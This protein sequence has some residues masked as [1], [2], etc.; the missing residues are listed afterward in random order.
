MKSNQTHISCLL[1]PRTHQNAIRIMFI[2][3]WTLCLVCQVHAAPEATTPRERNQAFQQRVKMHQTGVFHDLAFRCVG[4]V[5]MSG[6]V[7]DIQP[8]PQDPYSFY[9]AYATGG[10]W[11]TENN[12][13]RFTSLFEGQNA[14]A[15]GAIAVDPKNPDT[16]WAG[17]GEANSARSHYSGTGIYKTVDAGK[18]WQ[19]M[20]LR[21]SH[22]IAR[23]LVD[24]DNSDVVI[25]VAMGHL[26]TDNVQ[27]GIFVT[28]DGGQT[29]KKTLYLNPN[30][31]AIDVTLDPADPD[32][33]YAAMWQKTR[34]AWNMDESGAHSGIY[35]STDG[36]ES[37]K[38][39]S[40]FES[41]EHVGRIGLAV[42]P[43]N[44]SVVYALLDN[45]TPKP[46]E[47]NEGDKISARKLPTM[48]KADVLALTDRELGGFLRQSGFHEDHTVESIRAQLDANDLT[49]QD[50]V[51]YVV[52]LNPEAL[53]PQIRG[54]EVYRSEDAGVTWTKMNL[55]DLDSMYN[56]AGY[57]FGQ[58]R[59]A[60]DNEDLIYIM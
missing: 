3:V 56:I 34:T 58:I 16:L 51:D 33:L 32:I 9:V 25:V 21:D 48:S 11:K 22:H 8:S 46:D 5:V 6:R 27:R 7:V 45:Q 35:K 24:P 38:R 10:L 28:R 40:G 23:I 44:S 54:A 14:V 43:S 18:T 47:D 41:G 39:L 60:P 42:A 26:Y 12:G 29:W 37:W 36:G 20:G 30:T 52:R 53:T 4:P 31:G 15:L 57:Y 49:V 59:V 19:C 13:M 17:T 2:A 1:T 50:L 55:T